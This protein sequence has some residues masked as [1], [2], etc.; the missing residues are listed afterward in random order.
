MN[1]KKEISLIIGCIFKELNYLSNLLKRLDQN[2]DFLNEIICVISG[3][4]TYEK[5]ESLSELRNI[6]NIRLEIIYLEKIVM[7]GEARNI[8]ILKSNFDYICLLDSHTL[9]A[10]NWLS[11][12]IKIMDKKNLKGVLGR[13]RYIAKNQIEHCFISASYGNNPLFTVPGSIFKK[14]F[15]DEVGLFLPHTRSG[16]D[17]EWIYRSRFFQDNLKQINVIPLNYNGLKGMSFL[18]LCNKWYIY[19]KSSY[20]IPRLIIQRLFYLSILS[21]SLILIGL[22]WNDKLA[23]WDQNSL[24]YIPHISKVIVILISLSY[25]I[26]RLIILPVKKNVKIY[27]F[28]LIEITKFIFISIT[29]DFVKLIAFINHKR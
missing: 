28:N 23:N 18:E 15:F 19:Y 6:T 1:K 26:Y 7:P 3:V 22:S 8:G 16:E 29:L 17:S 14:T 24:F 12:S 9:P 2:I 10:K 21:L 13:T 20:L 25:L 4:D 5:I 27:K 11:N